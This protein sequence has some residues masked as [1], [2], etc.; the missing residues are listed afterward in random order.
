MLVTLRSQRGIN[1]HPFLIA[2]STSRYSDVVKEKLLFS[3]PMNG[4]VNMMPW[5][6]FLTVIQQ[7]F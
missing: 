1:F 5:F 3:T 2:L 6:Y 4:R 7:L